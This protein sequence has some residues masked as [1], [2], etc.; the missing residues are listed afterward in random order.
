MTRAERFASE[1]LRGMHR[2]PGKRKQAIARQMRQRRLHRYQ[3]SLRR[4]FAEAKLA[5]RSAK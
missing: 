1:S 3:W 5:E 4:L 2:A